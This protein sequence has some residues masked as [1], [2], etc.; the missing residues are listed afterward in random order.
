M[1][2]E[3]QGQIHDVRDLIAIMEAI[4]VIDFPN[5]SGMHP[6]HAYEKTSKA[7]DNYAD[8]FKEHPNR[9]NERKFAALEY[10][11]SDALDLY[12]RIRRDFREVFN[13]HVSPSAG[14][15][16]SLRKRERASF[17]SSVQQCGSVRIPADQGRDVPL[18]RRRSRNCVAYDRIQQ[19]R[20]MGWAATAR[21][22]S[23]GIRPP[24]SLSGRLTT[25][26][27]T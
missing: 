21:F 15:M 4:N 24:R 14:R 10:I 25:R 13:E 19:P 20:V 7:L 18:L 3:R 11:L 27:A 17:S 23:C 2:G 26:G 9:L 6:I 1:E 12:D 8:D 5:D 16:P 22:V